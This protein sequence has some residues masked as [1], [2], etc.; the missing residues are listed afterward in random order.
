MTDYR[1]VHIALVAGDA[2]GEM[3]ARIEKE[4]NNAAREGWR[5]KTLMPDV[6]EGTTLGCWL[7]FGS[8]ES[9]APDLPLV[10]EA[11]EI[12]IHAAEDE[13]PAPGI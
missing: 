12:L 13:R 3:S 2:H 10:A 1:V 11:A 5:L 8:A 9:A 7:I 6:T 4:C